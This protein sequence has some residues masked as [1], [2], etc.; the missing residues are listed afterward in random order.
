MTD[1]KKTPDVTSSIIEPIDEIFLTEGQLAERHQ[2]SP[3]TLRNDRVKGGYIPFIKI[4][5]H[6]RYRLTDVLEHE[7][8]HRMEST[9]SNKAKNRRSPLD[10][11]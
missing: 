2:R 11:A 1:H 10:D 9:C 5:H 8:L 6:V 3:K 4:G 7:R